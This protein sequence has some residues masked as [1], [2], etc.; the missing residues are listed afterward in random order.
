VVRRP[1]TPDA[2]P[3][4]K[5]HK[6]KRAEDP[7]SPKGY[8]EASRG[9]RTEGRGQR[10]EDRGRKTEDRGQKMSERI[11]S[12]RELNVYR[13]AYELQQEIFVLTKKFPK[14]NSTRSQTKSGD[15]L[16]L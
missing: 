11:E 3:E 9:Q 14:K 5:G 13:L 8:T 4:T 10:T 12:F 1:K 7:A 16:V 15:L 2:R 6:C